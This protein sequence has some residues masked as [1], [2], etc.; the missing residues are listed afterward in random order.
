MTELGWVA[1]FLNGRFYFHQAIETF[2]V[3]KL[4]RKIFEKKMMG[5]VGVSEKISKAITDVIAIVLSTLGFYLI[6]FLVT[7][8]IIKFFSTLFNES[9]PGSI[10]LNENSIW[11]YVVWII[12]ANF[13]SYWITR[14]IHKLV[15]KNDHSA[16][17]NYFE[18]S[19]MF[20]LYLSGLI[21]IV[22]ALEPILLE[23]GILLTAVDNSIGIQYF[24][25]I[26]FI[27]L[28]NHNIYKT[29]YEIRK[30]NG[31]EPLPW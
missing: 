10:P 24:A 2:F 12:G 25:L 15:A 31:D 17:V 16:F 11:F 1:L 14:G 6:V 29:M 22:L 19:H 4:K 26:F 8:F 27:A 23:K 30:R 9:A 5:M 20:I 28:A 18:K 21:T 3:V 7:P 13:L